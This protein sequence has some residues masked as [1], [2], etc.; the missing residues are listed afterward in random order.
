MDGIVLLLIL[1]AVLGL[2][3]A[4]IAANKGRSFGVWWLYGFLL[5]LIAFLH[6]LALSTDQETIEK[7]KMDSGE[8]KKCP[9]C[10]EAIKSEAIICKHCNR[11]VPT[12]NSNNK[13]DFLANLSSK[14]FYNHKNG[15]YEL[16]DSAVM[17]TIQGMK[18]IRDKLTDEECDQFISKFNSIIFS[19]EDGLPEQLKAEFSERYRY[20]LLK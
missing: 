9:F 16:D 13:E 2:L 15:D 19:L 10:A 17:I 14:K 3:P 1:S 8:I 11:E 12:I 20:W 18:E 4:K 5:F 6:S 7:Q